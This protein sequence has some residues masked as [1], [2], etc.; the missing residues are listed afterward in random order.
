MPPPY[1]CLGGSDFTMEFYTCQQ[2]AGKNACTQCLPKCVMGVILCKNK[3]ANKLWTPENFIKSC[4]IGGEVTAVRNAS[5][6][7]VVLSL[8][9][10][11]SN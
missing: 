2:A 8:D 3:M 11:L 9:K 7:F 6:F 4:R 5:S 1:P 10:Y